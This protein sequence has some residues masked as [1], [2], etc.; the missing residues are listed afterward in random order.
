LREEQRKNRKEYLMKVKGLIMFLA[1][2][3]VCCVAGAQTDAKFPSQITTSDG[4]LYQDTAK[5]RV[6]P[7]GILVKF[8]P[9][10]G[11]IGLA[12]LR[13]QVLPED[14]QKQ[15]GYDP[16]SAAEFEKQQAQA[17]DHW[18]SQTAASDA[19][20]RYRAIAE[21][22]Q[23]LAGSDAVSYTVSLDASGKISAQG[24]TG[25][26]PSLSVTNV[27][28]PAFVAFP[29]RNGLVT[30]YA[31]MQVPTSTVIMSK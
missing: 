24:V 30:D 13:F 6:D 8:Q 11:G 29:Y 27:S 26:A 10:T 23:A 4:T 15:Y 1:A 3:L 16:K 22:N 28:M 14:L 25:T 31:P 17:T 5:L 21:L 18:R 12:K 9:A 2:P 7:D 20:A 19:M